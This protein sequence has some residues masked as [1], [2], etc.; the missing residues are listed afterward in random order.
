MGQIWLLMA[1][2]AIFGLFMGI[3][4]VYGFKYLMARPAT[5]FPWGIV[6][7]GLVGIVFFL[8]PLVVLP[9]PVAEKPLLLFDFYLAGFFL[10]VLVALGRVVLNRMRAKRDNSRV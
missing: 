9:K 5:G 2:S 3:V 4:Y 7:P 6:L 1:G 8:L 10:P